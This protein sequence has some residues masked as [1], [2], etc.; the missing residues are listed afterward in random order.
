MLTSQ[1]EAQL[2]PYLVNKALNLDCRVLAVNGWVDHVH[3]VISIPPK[4]SVSEIV[5]RLKGASAHDLNIPW[6][7]G[8]GVMTVGEREKHIP[9]R[10][11]EN[12]KQHHAA[13]TTNAWLERSD[14]ND[15]KEHQVREEG[16]EYRIEEGGEDLLF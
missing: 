8:Y 1:I 7:E 13:K 16:L 14:D 4:V 11:V 10:Y 3:L 5:K 2:Y 15:E 12:Q 9:V 6:Q